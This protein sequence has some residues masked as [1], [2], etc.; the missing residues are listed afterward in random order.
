MDA[1]FNEESVPG[2]VNDDSV[3]SLMEE[4]AAV[5]KQLKENGFGTVRYENGLGEIKL[6][7]D[8]SMYQYISEHRDRQYVKVLLA[9]Q[10]RPYIPDIEEEVIENYVSND[11]YVI[12]PTGRSTSF[13][14]ISAAIYGSLAAGFRNSNWSCHSYVVEGGK[15]SISVHYVYSE[16]C[17]S[18][19]PIVQ[20]LND[21]FP[22]ELQKCPI[23][24]N[25]K[26]IHLSQ[27]HGYKD[28]N[29]LAQ[30]LVTSEYI[31]EI[32]NSTDRNSKIRDF[33]ELGDNNQ[34]IFTLHKAGGFRLVAQTTA[35]NMSELKRIAVILEKKF[36]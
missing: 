5:V 25:E 28:L 30:R 23:A 3:N 32:I 27:H 29:I 7:N 36:L 20:W 14:V 2:D 34:L 13:G 4:Y 33:I 8:Y 11:Y 17:F 26:K 19:A 6:R 16:N 21:V 18:H 24:P 35:R 22:K 1:F 15:D 12:T 9:F 10:S 31:T